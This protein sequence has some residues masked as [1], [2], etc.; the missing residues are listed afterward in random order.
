MKRRNTIALLAAAALF[1]PLQSCLKEQADIFEESASERLQNRIKDAAKFLEASQNGWVM[2][3]YPVT[4]SV[5]SVDS[6]HDAMNC[7]YAYTLKFSD[8]KVTAMSERDYTTRD[9]VFTVA[10]STY[11]ITDDEGPVLSFDTYNEVLHYWSTPG[12]SSSLYEGRGGDF[13]F[14]I[15]E[16]SPEYIRM[17]GKRWKIQAEMFP[18]PTDDF[19]SYLKSI[20]RQKTSLQG[21]TY[22]VTSAG[23][24]VEGYLNETNGS[25]S[26]SRYLRITLPGEDGI[27]DDNDER[28]KIPFTILPDRCRLYE[29]MQIGEQSFQEFTLNPKTNDI[30]VLDNKEITWGHP[31]NYLPK[32][33]FVGNY[34]LTYNKSDDYPSLQAKTM[35]VSIAQDEEG[36]LILKGLNEKYDIPLDYDEWR[37]TAKIAGAKNLGQVSTN[38]NGFARFCF[39]DSA[40]MLEDEDGQGYFSTRNHFY[41]RTSANVFLEIAWDEA[42]QNKPNFSIGSHNGWAILSGAMELHIPDGFYLHAWK[43]ATGSGSSADYGALE[44]ASGLFFNTGAKDADGNVVGS[45]ALPFVYSL[46]RK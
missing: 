30:V 8:G 15:A 3:I 5:Y 4:P 17:T 35:D 6:P 41:Y 23:E 34:T 39:A 32:D 38:Q 13:E 44:A 12:A 27:I 37:G 2:L 21:I 14:V 25:A 42:D 29:P 36:N 46:T 18:L 45:R 20:L 11:K 43:T 19:E 9:T 33:K 40:Y 1:L 7:G 24:K 31:F 16:A 28:I 10:E 26:S 22:G